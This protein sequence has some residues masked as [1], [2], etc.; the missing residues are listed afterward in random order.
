MFKAS[1][2]EEAPV[3]WGSSL[4]AETI[5]VKSKYVLCHHLMFL[6][7]CHEEEPL[8]CFRGIRQR[9]I[10]HFLW[11]KEKSWRTRQ[12]RVWWSSSPFS[13]RSFL[14]RLSFNWCWD[15]SVVNGAGWGCS[16]QNYKVNY[17]DN[18]MCPLGKETM[19]SMKGTD[20]SASSYWCSLVWLR[21]PLFLEPVSN[22]TWTL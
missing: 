6:L 15:F 9:K 18:K 13:E 3:V 17:H 14:D 7:D 1:E 5:L 19:W 2:L 22:G 21:L 12:D 4:F 11:T 20:S 8:V 16:H 10:W